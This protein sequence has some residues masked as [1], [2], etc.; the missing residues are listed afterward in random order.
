MTWIAWKPDILQLARSSAAVRIVSR[1]GYIG[2]V[3]CRIAAQ[4]GRVGCTTV[5]KYCIFFLLWGLN[6]S[7]WVTVMLCFQPWI[8]IIYCLWFYKTIC[9]SL[10]QIK[11]S[12]L[13]DMWCVCVCVYICMYVCRVH[14]LF[15]MHL[16]DELFILQ[17]E[18]N[19]N[20]GVVSKSNR[21][22]CLVTKIL[23]SLYIYSIFKP[24]VVLFSSLYI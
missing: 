21:K 4:I 12:F 22:Y 11:I 10:V 24:N 9:S 2:R 3:T 18:K 14:S 23:Y 15:K 19:L 20:R 1:T 16:W 7:V 5:Q 17:I 13:W 6:R 8:F